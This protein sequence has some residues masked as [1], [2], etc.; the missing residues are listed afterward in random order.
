MDAH[1]KP[2]AMGALRCDAGSFAGGLRPP[3]TPPMRKPQTLRVASACEV[4]ETASPSPCFSFYFLKPCLQ[5]SVFSLR[6]FVRAEEERMKNRYAISEGC[7]ETLV[8][9]SLDML[10]V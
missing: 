10:P 3:H 2:C 4:S 7:V 6:A 9:S 8:P 5:G 1:G